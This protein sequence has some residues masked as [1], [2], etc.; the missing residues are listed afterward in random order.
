[1]GRPVRGS[2]LCGAVQYTV[3]AIAPV[4]GVCHCSMCRKFHGAAGA[5]LASV[6]RK[7]LHWTQGESVLAAFVADNGTTRR[8]C[9][10]CGSSL[11]FETPRAPDAIELAIA[12][13]DEPIDITLDAHIFVES[14][15]GW[16]DI[17]DGLPQYARG[18]DSERVK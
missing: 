1:M 16:Y 12:T 11:T 4:T 8:F 3:D 14:K 9:R 18:R 13:L 2:C 6:P 15:P 7:A 5:V 17:T 10:R